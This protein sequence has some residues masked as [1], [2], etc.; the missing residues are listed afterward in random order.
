MVFQLVRN[1]T[2]I[3]RNAARYCWFKMDLFVS[4]LY[5]KPAR[6]RR[7]R[8]VRR[9]Q[10]NGSSASAALHRAPRPDPQAA[11]RE[12]GPADAAGLWRSSR[13]PG[14]EGCRPRRNGAGGDGDSR[15][16]PARQLRAEGPCPSLSP[17][18]EGTRKET[19]AEVRPAG[20]WVCRRGNPR[21]AAGKRRTPEYSLPPGYTPACSIPKGTSGCL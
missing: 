6:E 13:R 21:G 5:V 10:S 1:T 19:H 8:D 7:S 14:E 18:S 2:A 20:L 12:G 16:P 9:H 4:K 17:R 11:P 3:W 15:Q